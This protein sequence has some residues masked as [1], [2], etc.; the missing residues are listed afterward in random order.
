MASK[1]D[2]KEKKGC[3]QLFMVT[4]YDQVQNLYSY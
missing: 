3:V 1:A 2:R 4:S